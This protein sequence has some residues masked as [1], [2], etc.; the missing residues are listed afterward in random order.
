M[1]CAAGSQ[2]L[3]TVSEIGMFD[4]HGLSLLTVSGSSQHRDTG[5]DNHIQQI[6]EVLT[7]TV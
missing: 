2:M 7:A 5:H 1:P 6:C 4:G 3:A